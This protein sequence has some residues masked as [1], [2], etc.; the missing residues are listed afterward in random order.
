MEFRLDFQFQC[1]RIPTVKINVQANWIN[2]FHIA[3][4]T[5]NSS[6]LSLTNLYVCVC[7]WAESRMHKNPEIGCWKLISTLQITNYIKVNKFVK[8]YLFEEVQQKYG[9]IKKYIIYIEKIWNALS[10]KSKYRENNEWKW[11]IRITKHFVKNIK[12]I[13]HTYNRN[14]STIKLFT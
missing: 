12:N 13:E 7:V 5:N 6:R 4:N 3:R 1:N 11:M 10:I 14:E 9:N 8:F 2:A